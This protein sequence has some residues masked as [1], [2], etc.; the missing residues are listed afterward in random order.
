M[1]DGI[2]HPHLF[3]I[4]YIFFTCIKLCENINSDLKTNCIRNLKKNLT[5]KQKNENILK[6]PKIVWTKSKT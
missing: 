3:L 5:Q 4:Y 6:T 2:F 1:L